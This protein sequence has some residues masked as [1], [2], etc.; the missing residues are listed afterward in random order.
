MKKAR[1]N[2]RKALE[3]AEK[4][5]QTCVEISR[6]YK[7]KQDQKVLDGYE[8]EK[9][10]INRGKKT[11]N[12][13]PV[14]PEIPLLPSCPFFFP[15]YK[16]NKKKHILRAAPRMARLPVKQFRNGGVS[17]A[18]LDKRVPGGYISK[19]C[20]WLRRNFQFFKRKDRRCGKMVFLVAGRACLFHNEL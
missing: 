14:P 15:R 12:E 13:L 10:K 1:E 11:E 7:E 8:E 5:Y 17:Q 16:I 9:S 19:K 3:K 20:F 18:G 6:Q 4:D 2:R